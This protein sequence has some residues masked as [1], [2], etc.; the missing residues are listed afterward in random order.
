[1]YQNIN[2]NFK[3]SHKIKKIIALN[4]QIMLQLIFMVIKKYTFIQFVF[5]N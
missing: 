3:L 2:L 1:M 5:G 4:R